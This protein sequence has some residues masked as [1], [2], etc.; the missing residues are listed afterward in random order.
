MQVVN[1]NTNYIGHLLRVAFNHYPAQ[2]ATIAIEASSDDKELEV[3]AMRYFYMY[4]TLLT[5]YD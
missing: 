4:Y 1:E 3:N 5:C 2:F